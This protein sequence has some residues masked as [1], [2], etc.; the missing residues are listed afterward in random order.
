MRRARSGRG[1]A[2]GARRRRDGTRPIQARSRTGNGRALARGRN[3]PAPRGRGAHQAE[4]EH[5]EAG[6]AEDGVRGDAHPNFTFSSLL[7]TLSREASGTHTR[8]ATGSLEDTSAR[9][10]PPPEPSERSRSARSD[11]RPVAAGE[12]P[13]ARRPGRGGQTKRRQGRAGDLNNGLACTRKR[14]WASIQVTHGRTV[15]H[16]R[17]AA[18]PR[19]ARAFPTLFGASARRPRALF[20]RASSPSH[21]SF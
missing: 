17:E 11:S 14:I 21:P 5:E 4:Y 15:S 7:G 6:V 9:R 2:S 1:V 3:E 12:A 16:S 8:R 20:R 18:R 13:S 19:G 10:G